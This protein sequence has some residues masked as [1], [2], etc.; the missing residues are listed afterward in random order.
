[1]EIL[2]MAKRLDK[3][4][5]KVATWKNFSS[6]VVEGLEY[7]R[8]FGIGISDKSHNKQ[9][10]VYN[11]E[12]KEMD[13]LHEIGYWEDMYPFFPL[14]NEEYHHLYNVPLRIDGVS[15]PQPR[16]ADVMGDGASVDLIMRP[17][18][19]ILGAVKATQPKWNGDDRITLHE[20][21]AMVGK[22]SPY[23]SKIVELYTGD[24]PIMVIFMYDNTM[25]VMN[26]R[27]YVR[28]YTKRIDKTTF[29]DKN[30]GY[31]TLYQVERRTKY[32]RG[33]KMFSFKPSL[34]MG[35]YGDK[36]MTKAKRRAGHKEQ[37]I[38]WWTENGLMF[39]CDYTQVTTR[40]LNKL[41]KSI[42]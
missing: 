10:K 28:E 7:A 1:M 14:S 26:V 38:K 20:G 22:A 2:K 6:H 27:K 15:C 30:S 19:P 35:F 11:P 5:D 31:Q 16:C 13:C 18:K 3:S 33:Y 21:A 42:E 8:P 17:K 40:K 41:F 25:T 36:S 24:T 37:C 29:I 32:K 12:T 23:I 39:T 9:G 34:I 4:T